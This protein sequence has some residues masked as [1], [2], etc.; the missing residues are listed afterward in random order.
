MCLFFVPRKRPKRA[1][2]S[3][4]LFDFTICWKLPIFWHVLDVFS[5]LS[6]RIKSIP[7]H[8]RP[9]S[10]D[11]HLEYQQQGNR[12]NLKIHFFLDLGG[13]LGGLRKRCWGEKIC[14]GYPE[15]IGQQIRYLLNYSETK[16][17]EGYT[18]LMYGTM[19]IYRFNVFT[20]D[21][22]LFK[23]LHQIL[24]NIHILYV[25]CFINLKT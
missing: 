14:F 9:A 15:I 1:K 21:S 8:E 24:C 11:T 19:K 3:V 20:N 6:V 12:S 7:F 13:S 2:I 25:R 17:G 22:H 16:R 23:I 5:V 10:H 18:L 4:F